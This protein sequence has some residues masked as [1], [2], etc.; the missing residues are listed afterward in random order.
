[1]HANDERLNA[2]HDAHRRALRGR[3]TFYVYEGSRGWEAW[4]SM[5]PVRIDPTIAF[6]AVT[7]DGRLYARVGR[8]QEQLV[9][10]F[11]KSGELELV[12]NPRASHDARELTRHNA[13]GDVISFEEARGRRAERELSGLMQELEAGVSRVRLSVYEVLIE[14]G[15]PASYAEAAAADIAEGW[16]NEDLVPLWMHPTYEGPRAGDIAEYL[17]RH[18][19]AIT[20]TGFLKKR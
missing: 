1:M 20:K 14:L 9:G 13:N 11:A 17:R 5:P 6:Y 16:A 10:R 3:Q 2:L 7:T 18:D 19:L 12:R 8:E 4:P 15:L